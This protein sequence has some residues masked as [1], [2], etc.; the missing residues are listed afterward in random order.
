MIAFAKAIIRLNHFK[1]HANKGDITSLI[2]SMW[3]WS[4]EHVSPYLK[5]Q[6]MPLN[7]PGK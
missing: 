2:S 4:I 6:P 3:Q 5:C 1:I 7:S